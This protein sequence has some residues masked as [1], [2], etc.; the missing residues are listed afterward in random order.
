MADSKGEV[1]S[2]LKVLTATIIFSRFIRKEPAQNIGLLMPTTSV[3]AMLN[4]ATLMTGKTVVNLNYTAS[5]DA[6]RSAIEKAE[7]Q[8]IYTA[9]LF[10]SKLKAKGVD[11]DAIL[12]SSKVVYLEELNT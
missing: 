8:T 5:V 4:M 11:T 1:M 2:Y 7:I 10:I 6:L 3:G 12:G 9:K